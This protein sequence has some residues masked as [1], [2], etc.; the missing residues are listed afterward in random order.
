MVLKVAS[1]KIELYCS[2]SVSRYLP[3]SA[4]CTFRIFSAVSWKQDAQVLS[5]ESAMFICSMILHLKS[6]LSLAH[7]SHLYVPS[8]FSTTFLLHS[9]PSAWSPQALYRALSL[10]K[11]VMV[12][13]VVYTKQI[14]TG[15]G[16]KTLLE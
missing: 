15:D 8:P 10:L 6:D 9:L 4:D 7:F 16:D 13:K 3:R 11:K 5:V 1:R 2:S 12:A 14:E